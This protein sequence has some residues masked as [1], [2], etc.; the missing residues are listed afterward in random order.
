MALRTRLHLN[1]NKGWVS[2]SPN[3]CYHP[4]C[5]AY[6][7]GT[8]ARRS[9]ESLCHALPMLGTVTSAL[10]ATGVGRGA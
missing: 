2:C 6:L 9:D 3:I 10:S 4:A 5:P 1:T 7:R 8:K